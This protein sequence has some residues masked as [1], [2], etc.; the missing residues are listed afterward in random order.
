MLQALSVGGGGGERIQIL[1]AVVWWVF[2]CGSV[3]FVVWC[4]CV[5]DRSELRLVVCS[6]SFFL[7]VEGFE[8]AGAAM[9]LRGC[10][11]VL[12]LLA[13]V[14]SS[15]GQVECQ[16]FNVVLLYSMESCA[17]AWIVVMLRTVLRLSSCSVLN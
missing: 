4:F 5:V 8:M 10:V 14:S 1:F 12:V 2:N 15:Y 9:A 16:P 13:A 11:V 6:L 3:V 7:C 17:C